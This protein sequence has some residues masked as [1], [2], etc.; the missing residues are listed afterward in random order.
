MPSPGSDSTERVRKGALI[1]LAVYGAALAAIAFWP[2]P[3]DAG[4]EGVIGKIIERFPF[5]TYN[6]LEFAAN[7]LLF[8]PYGVLLAL[9]A[10]RALV[11]PIVIVTTVAIECI[12]AVALDARTPTVLD[13]V[14]N[15]TGGA[16]GLLVVAAL[17][18]AAT[19][20]DMVEG[21]VHSG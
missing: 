7:I 5:V 12:Q 10:S 3:V 4:I 9:I 1:L 13:I 19:G 16:L 21:K 20:A 17:P 2:E 18:R 6:R 8:V 11:L 14:A 15:T